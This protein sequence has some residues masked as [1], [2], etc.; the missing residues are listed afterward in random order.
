MKH[1]TPND[2]IT[3]SEGR[4][5]LGVSQAKMAYLIRDGSIRYFVNPLD[6]RVKLLSKA[7]VLALIPQRASKVA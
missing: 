4:R 3:V 5:L 1:E 2:L 7:E 6:K